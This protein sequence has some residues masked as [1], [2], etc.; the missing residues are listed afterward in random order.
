M[1]IETFFETDYVDAASYDSIRKIASYVDGLKNSGRKFVWTMLEK[2]IVKGI[3]VSRLSATVAEYTEYLH[4]EESL[5]T[6]ITSFPKRYPGT[7]NMPLMTEE[8]NFGKRFKNKASAARYVFTALEPRTKKL[9]MNEDRSTLD[10]QEFEGTD[11]EPK[12]LVPILP[13]ILINGSMNGITTGFTQEILARPAS[14]MLRTTLQYIR[15]DKNVK[16][17]N[18][19]WAGF[20]GKVLKD[21]KISGRWAIYGAFEKVNSYTLRITEIPVWKELNQYIKVLAELEDN[22]IIN[23]FEDLCRDERFNFLVKVPKKFFE[24]TEESQFETLGL[25]VNFTEKYNCIGL[26]NNIVEFKSPEEIFLAYAKVRED[27]YVDRIADQI[28]MQTTLLKQLASKYIFVKGIVDG[29]IIVQNKKKDVI[30]KTLDGVNGITKKDDSY[31]YLLNMS[32]YSLTNEK[33][34]ELKDEISRTKSKLEF[35]KGVSPLELWDADIK[36]LV[37]K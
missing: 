12:Y 9:F 23:G 27:H 32:I 22:K 1:K 16:I 24:M 26:E 13:T 3:K 5:Q 17:P 33:L 6:V 19:G 4:A 15:G 20:T 31:N 21:K 7:N 36:C 25:K 10:H 11:I 18:P 14:A 35:Y 2:N 30:I 8:A 34:K 29:K 28:E 37:A